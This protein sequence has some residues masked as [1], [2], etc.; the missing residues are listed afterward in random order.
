MKLRLLLLSLPLVMLLVVVGCRRLQDGGDSVS[1]E[2]RLVEL[3]G[4]LPVTVGTASVTLD[5]VPATISGGTWRGLI[6]L[7]GAQTATELV[8]AI[9]GVTVLTRQIAIEIDPLPK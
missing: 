4:S 7:T 1:L 6:V 9:D 5:G 8:V 3:S 2:T